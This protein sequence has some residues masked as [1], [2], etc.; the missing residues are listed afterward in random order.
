MNFVIHNLLT[1]FAQLINNLSTTYTHIEESKE[2]RILKMY[3]IYKEEIFKNALK[4][5]A[6]YYKKN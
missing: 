4:K 6:S 1:G 2:S 3:I 5:N